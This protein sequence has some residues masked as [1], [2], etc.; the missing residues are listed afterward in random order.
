MIDTRSR[1]F[2]LLDYKEYYGIDKSFSDAIDLIKDI[3]SV[4]LLNYI[5][6][7]GVNL[8]LHENT[9]HTGKIQF[10]LV[11]SL[12]GKCDQAIQQKW[13]NEVKKQAEKGH[14]PILFW[15]Y[16]NLLFYGLIFKT[17]NNKP[18]R[19]LTSEEA[20][21]VFDVYLIINGI[22][23]DKVQIE[24][25]TI[26]KADREE[27]I[28]DV[29]LPSFIYQK[30]YVSTVDFSNQVTRGVTFF[31]YL[32]NDPKYKTLVKEYYE[33]KNVS[34]SL[35]M[36][37]NLMVIFSEINLGKDLDRRNQL[38]NLKEYFIGSEVDL[39]YIET[40]C[41]NPEI[42]SYKEDVS[43]GSLRSKFLYKLNKFQ[44]L[45][46]DVNFLID[47]F[48]KAQIFSFN[49]FLKSK[50]IKGDFLSE[51]GKNFTENIYLPLVLDTCF[52]H[53]FKFYGDNC[54]NS[55]NE[56]LCDAYL[57]E[58]NKI[59]LIEFK[60]ILL[61]A[62]IKNSAEQEELFAEFDKKFVSN[63]TGKP[64]GIT[65]LLNAIKDIDANSI[66]FDSSVPKSEIEIYPVIVYT[67]LSFGTEGINKIFK[68]KF[69]VEINKL[70]LQN[71]IVK[72]V[73]FINLN[74]LEIRE[75]YFAKKLLN[76][77]VMLDGYIEHIK[78]PNY[79]LTPFEVFSRFYMNMYV[80][81]ELGATSSYL[82]HQHNIVTAK[83]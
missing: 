46:L 83:K 32:E 51:K 29:M 26:E 74:F 7:F 23:N 44:F 45:I 6:G 5:A 8:Y 9:E 25:E 71:I 31:N 17:I 33:S 53:Y 63:Q 57:R 13:A 36:F 70:H 21:R 35:R 40:L 56:E 75:D 67:D 42:S 76:L 1:M 37:K 58:E 14:S 12:L 22:A 27:K 48:Y 39:D 2:L 66:S 79:L 59:C 15:T 73:T 43:F 19:D 72:D 68:D 60:D 38:A 49:A 77:F 16:S 62:S 65:Q 61:N 28:E 55:N 11:N 64:K 82:K 34:G 50:K 80:P 18:S 69:R 24:T 47:Q 10:M 78:D 3:P 52:S 54:K 30:D 20:I 81:E 41:I 4:T